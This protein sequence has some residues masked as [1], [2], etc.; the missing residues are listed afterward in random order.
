MRTREQI[1]A[2]AKTMKAYSIIVV[3]PEEFRQFSDR[4]NPVWDSSK[5]IN[6]VVHDWMI[7]LKS[8]PVRV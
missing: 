1:V 7:T 3:S 8:E 6:L 5:G 4:F 2:L